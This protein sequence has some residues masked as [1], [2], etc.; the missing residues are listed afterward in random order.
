M[1]DFMKRMALA[2]SLAS[3]MGC[4]SVTTLSGST[5]LPEIQAQPAFHVNDMAQMPYQ[6][7]ELFDQPVEITRQLSDHGLLVMDAEKSPATGWKLPEFGTYR[8]KVKS[9]VVREGL[10]DAATAFIPEAL[11]L[12]SQFELVRKIPASQ[13]K[14]EEANL[15]GEEYIVLEFVID[16]RDSLQQPIDY[17]VV[18]TSEEAK[19]QQVK[20][21]NP[22]VEYAKVRGHVLPADEEII[23]QP[24]DAGL[25]VLAAEPLLGSFASTVQVVQPKTPKYI[26]TS[27]PAAKGSQ[28]SSQAL[29]VSS[30]EASHRYL[31]QVR[32]LIE[33]KDIAGAMALRQG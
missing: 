18:R 10:G 7:I 25:I 29:A 12:D 28:D 33:K 3:L 31:Q 20:V 16:N 22:R 24:A 5:T 30:V 21:A 23:A 4:S 26:P 8:I 27:I 6:P 13:L 11:L 17:L 1:G 19:T 2:V 9:P 15:I 32:S 14:Y